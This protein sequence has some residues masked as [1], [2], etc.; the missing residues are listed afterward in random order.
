M[1]VSGG[2]GSTVVFPREAWLLRISVDG[3]ECI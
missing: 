2:G 1:S 3:Q